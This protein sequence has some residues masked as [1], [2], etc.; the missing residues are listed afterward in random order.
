MVKNQVRYPSAGCIVEFMQGNSPVQAWVVEEHS[1]QLRLYTVNKRET[2]L[3]ATRILPWAGPQY[4][5]SASRQEM[6][7]KLTQHKQ[8]RERIAAEADLAQLWEL[9][10]GEVTQAD[11]TWFAELLWPEPNIDA[12]AGLGAAMLS[13]KTHFKFSPPAFEV[14]TAEQVA[15]RLERQEK[16]EKQ[17]E[18]VGIGAEFFKRLYE[19]AKLRKEIDPA[20]AP[21]GE[22][23]ERLKNILLERIAD[24]EA[25]DPDGI[26]KLLSKEIAGKSGADEPFL[27]LLLATSWGIL[28]EHH[29]YWLD[30]A[31]YD[32][33]DEWVQPHAAAIAEIT[34]KVAAATVESGIG[35]GYVSIDPAS[36]KDWDDAAAIEK[37]ATGY[38]LSIA[39]ACPAAFWPFSS[40]LDSAVLRRATSLYLPEAELFMIPPALCLDVFSLQAGKCKPALLV[41]M[42]LDAEGAVQEVTPRFEWIKIS[43]NLTHDATEKA[44]NGEPDESTLPYLASLQHFLELANILQK[45][46]IEAGAAITDRVDP[47][48]SLWQGNDGKTQVHLSTGTPLPLCQLIVGEV[49]ILA[50]NKLAAWGAERGIPLIYR[51]QNVKLPKEFAGVWSK[52]ED[53]SRILRALPPAQ[54]ELEPKPHAGVGMEVYSSF[55]APMRR[56]P[57]LLNE[58]QVLSYLQTGAPCFNYDQMKGILPLLSVRLDASGQ[59]QRFRP[60]YWKLVYFQQQEQK[61]KA[62]RPYYS[63]TISD[64]GGAYLMVSLDGY[65]LAV[66]G[67]KNLLDE[68]YAGQKVQVRL[69]KINPLRNEIVAVELVED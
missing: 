33:T 65:Q 22:V 38:K 29:N 48:I 53:I 55:T 20:L 39:L 49:M 10:Q 17:H 63:G 58:A 37:T 54:L 7:E 1:G 14:Y 8:E 44:L 24:P 69:G 45:R 5:S 23:A 3:S 41:D 25:H 2:K 60:R 19:A 40:P 31:D 34:A 15:A 30:R 59:V 12:V 16:E 13:R 66:R 56:Y 46:R 52:P 36:T 61:N 50:N 4:S 26:W 51:T 67:A 62:S 11:A 32:P 57:D 27:P 28:P 35:S 9:A 64:V 21:E 42:L 47:K 18:T 43:A 68:P 6:Q